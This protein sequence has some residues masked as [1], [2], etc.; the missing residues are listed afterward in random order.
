[1]LPWFVLVGELFTEDTFHGN[2]KWKP[3]QVA[4]QAVIWSWQET[5]NVTDAFDQSLEMCRELGL[6]FAELLSLREQ[7]R[8]SKPKRKRSSTDYDPQDRSLANTMRVLRKC[9]GKLDKECDAENGLLDKLSTAKVQRY[10][11]R[12]DKRSRY[13]PKNPDKKPLGDPTV[14]KLTTDE[15]KKLRDYEPKVAA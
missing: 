10:K 3:E 15:R 1:M 9:L 2:T 12:T 11:N 13:R 7:I 6:A 14:R 8:A 5:K 4:A